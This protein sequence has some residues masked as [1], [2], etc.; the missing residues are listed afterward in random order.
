M[1]GRFRVDLEQLWNLVERI[2][3]F[4]Q[5]LESMLNDVDSKVNRLHISWAGAAAD[6]HRQ[7]QDEWKHGAVQMRAALVTMRQIAVTAHNNYTLAASA[8][9]SMWRQEL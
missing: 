1:T 8:N 7:A 3:Q 9:A 6:E 5:H 2:D 4:D